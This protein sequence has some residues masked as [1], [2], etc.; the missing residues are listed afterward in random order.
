VLLNCDLGEWSG[1]GVDSPDRAIMPYIDLANIACGMHAGGPLTMRQTLILAR[2]Q[3]V[4]IGAHPGYA[5]AANFGRLSV[6]HSAEELIALIHYQAGA[7]AGMAATLGL[8]V[9]YVKPHGALYNDMMAN[10]DI[11]TAV[12]EAIA[13]LPGIDRLMLLA[14]ADADRHR[15]E[16]RHHG[17]TLIFETFAD[18]GY[19][20]DGQLLPRDRPGAVHGRE[21]M[22]DQVQQ[23]CEDGTVT[24]ASGHVLAI[25][26]DTLC[27]HGDNPAAVATVCAIRELIR[28]QPIHHQP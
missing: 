28:R 6:P 2:S 15:R 1:V 18:R 13:G 16:A 14:T 27:V 19:G 21:R 11:R 24:T 12:L 8:T 4:A 7:L 25:D 22:L 3:G 20:D 5:D 23:L 26:A 10:V 17:V 9:D